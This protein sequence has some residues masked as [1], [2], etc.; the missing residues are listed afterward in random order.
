MNNAVKQI[1]Q[2]SALLKC[3]DA[4]PA[5]NEY[6]MWCQNMQNG[7]L[8]PISEHILDTIL[9]G[10]KSAFSLFMDQML[11]MDDAQKSSIKAMYNHTETVALNNLKSDLNSKGLLSQ[12]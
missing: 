10:E 8:R 4:N 6:N 1:Q 7:I 3:L 12:Q 2:A 11:F 9:E 5:C